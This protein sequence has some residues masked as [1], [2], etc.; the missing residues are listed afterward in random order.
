MK[1][2]FC[3]RCRMGVTPERARTAVFIQTGKTDDF[4]SYLKLHLHL[5][6]T[7][8][9]QPCEKLSAQFLVCFPPP[10]FQKSFHFTLKW[11]T[12]LK[13]Q[14]TWMYLCFFVLVFCFLLRLSRQQKCWNLWYMCM[15]VRAYVCGDSAANIWRVTGCP[16]TRLAA[17]TLQKKTW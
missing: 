4:L 17:A 1:C 6:W 2:I 8:F 3:S 12:T 13:N 15:C 11:M 10:S 7:M 16:T 14:S 9:R 5:C